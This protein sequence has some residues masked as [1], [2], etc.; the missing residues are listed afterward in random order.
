MTSPWDKWCNLKLRVQIIYF[1]GP[2]RLSTLF[3]CLV[4]GKCFKPTAD[5]TDLADFQGGLVC[6][7]EWVCVHQREREREAAEWND[8]TTVCPMSDMSNVLWSG[9]LLTPYSL[10]SYLRVT[11]VNV[12]KGPQMRDLYKSRLT[13]SPFGRLYTDQ[14]QWDSVISG[15]SAVYLFGAAH[16]CNL[17]WS[18]ATALQ[19]ILHRF[20]CRL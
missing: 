8:G 6:V 9:C 1:G 15:E 18:D 16:L 20:L 5:L 12:P 4:G 14:C 19:W 11:D 17:K 7:C 10:N 2:M 3:S 13:L